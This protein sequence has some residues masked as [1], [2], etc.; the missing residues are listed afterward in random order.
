METRAS[1]ILVGAFLLVLVAGLFAFTLWV[2]KA[3][4]EAEAV[5]YYIYFD[6]N[7]SG[8]KSGST[9]HY[10]GVPVGSVTDIRIDPENFQRIR[11][12]VSLAGDTPIKTDTVAYLRLEGVTGQRSIEIK[13]GSAGAPPLAALPGQAYP[14]IPSRPSSLETLLGGA[15][16]LLEEATLAAKELADLLNEENRAAVAATLKNLAT[17]SDAIAARST[18]IGQTLTSVSAMAEKMR[19]AA[20]ELAT[21]MA[22]ARMAFA[23]VDEESAAVGKDLHALIAD[24]RTTSASLTETSDELH[25]MIAENREPVKGFTGEGLYDLSLLIGELH[26]LA[27]NLSRIADEFESNP[28]GFL[29]GTPSKELEAP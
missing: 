26:R 1:Y 21:T 2:T 27:E 4:R 17:V 18:E 14:V 6:D 29:F 10:R 8:L 9:T 7:V 13:G 11:V 20:D 22:V 28:R 24:M 25:A 16:R 5:T 23:T 3:G 19:E 15:P 12:T